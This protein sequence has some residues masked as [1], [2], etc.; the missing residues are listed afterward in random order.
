MT[1]LSVISLYRMGG[2]PSEALDMIESPYLTIGYVLRGEHG[3][4]KFRSHGWLAK[5]RG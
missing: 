3:D 4:L 2:P 1:P 5:V